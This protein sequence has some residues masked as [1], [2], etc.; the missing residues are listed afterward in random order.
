MKREGRQHG[1]VRSS[2][3]LPA[4]SDPRPNNARVPNHVGAPPAAGFFAKAPSRPTNHSK[5][6]ARCRRERCKDCHFSPVSKSRDKA[7]GAHKLRSCDVVLNHR[8]VLWRVVD[9]GRLLSS[10]KISASEIVDHLYSS[11]QHEGD[12]YDDQNMEEG[13]G[14]GHGG[15]L[16]EAVDPKE[17]H[18]GAKYEET[19]E[20]STD[21]DEDSEIGFHMIGVTREYSDGED[22][23]VVDEI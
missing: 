6:T 22:W 5:C 13:A 12:D 16:L 23:L 18:S 21:S 4:E 1:M 8:L 3:I 9:G 15:P 11:S 7:K 14:Y 2:A 10:R 17:G 19:G 20:S